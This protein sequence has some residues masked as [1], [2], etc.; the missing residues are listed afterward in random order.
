MT[1]PAELKGRFQFRIFPRRNKFFRGWW[2]KWLRVVLVVGLLAAAVPGYLAVDWLSA[3]LGCRD[4]WPS[5]DVWSQD[6]EC[7]GI[8]SG[9][10]AF[11]LAEFGPVL[12]KIAEQNEN[13]GKA[14][15]QPGA[16]PVTVAVLST[17]T[18]PFGGGRTLHEIEGYAAAQVRANGV[19]CIHPIRLKVA[20]MGATEQAATTIA[21]RLKADP[22]VVAMVGMGLSDQRSADAADL[23]GGPDQPVPMVGT[24]ITAEGFDADGSAA[25]RPDFGTCDENVTYH[26]GV[27]EGYF[28]RVAH[29][30]A[31]QIRLLGD[32]LKAPPTFIVTPNDKRDPYT[33]TAL[34]FVRRLGEGPEVKFDPSDPATVGP[35]AQRICGRQGN[36]TAFYIAR[37]RDLG[38]FLR[39]IDEE[40][41]NGLCQ[42]GAITVVS[43]SDGVRMRVPE[44]DPGLEGAR[45]QA[46]A[47]AKF[48]D[49]TVRLVFTPLADSDSLRGSNSEYATLENLFGQNGFDLSHL[50]GGWAINAYDALH[51]VSEAVRTLSANSE[52]TRS[53]LN[54][55]IS[56]FAAGS[57]RLGAGG[58]IEFDNNGNRTGSPVAVQLCPARDGGRPATVRVDAAS[59]PESTHCPAVAPA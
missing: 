49:G 38:R 11:G 4:G 53:V 59:A 56:G 27:G 51:T 22:S 3:R 31:K 5:G 47:S 15:C 7:V 2:D 42:A 16:S 50:D 13:A 29:R 26:N 12:A 20:H 48:R 43:P 55:A 28:Y 45:Q 23:L 34:P 6:G 25:D 46:L 14:G 36:V 24:L 39:S 44:A 40:Y 19:G 37:S 8:T 18:T 1:L 21:A 58:Q 52:V 10:Y 35:A 32:F 33:C 54:S 41:R 30:N 17:L 9:P 57:G